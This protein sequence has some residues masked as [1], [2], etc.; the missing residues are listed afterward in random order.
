MRG[1]WSIAT[2]LFSEALL[3][4]AIRNFS[5]NR[6]V[7]AGKAAIFSL[8]FL[9]ISVT[10]FKRVLRDRITFWQWTHR[11]CGTLCKILEGL[12]LSA[13]VVGIISFVYWADS[14]ASPETQKITLR[15]SLFLWANG[16]LMM[17]AS[18]VLPETLR[19]TSAQRN[20]E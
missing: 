4:D 2:L 5:S 14:S 17:M 12:A 11:N 7:D 19:E 16:V 8:L 6:F 18:T 3:L 13:G 10:L 20:S 15:I 9:A 1:F